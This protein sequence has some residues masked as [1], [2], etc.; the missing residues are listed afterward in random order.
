MK[1]RHFLQIIG[2][3]SVA[4]GVFPYISCANRAEYPNAIESIRTK[5][6]LYIE[7]IRLTNGTYGRFRYSTD[8]TTPTLYSSTYAAMT[9]HLYNDLDSLSGQQRQ[10]WIDYLQSHQGDD[11]LF[12]DPIVDSGQAVEHLSWH[13]TTA[14]HCLGVNARK[15]LQ[16]VNKYK[17]KKVLQNWLD[18]RRWGY[19]VDYASNIIQN[20]CVALQYARD[21]H[22]DQDAAEPVDQILEYLAN[23]VDPKTGLWGGSE[24]DLNK[25]IELSH[26]IQAA[27]HFW[28]LWIYDGKM[29]PYPELAVDQLLKTQNKNGGYGCGVHNYKNPY[30]SSACE[31]ID[32][33]DAL[34][35]LMLVSD[36]RRDDIIKS[37][38]QALP[39][40][41]TNQTDSGSWVFLPGLEYQ[42]GHPEMYAGNG[43]GGMFPTWFRTL[44][45]AYLGKGL[46][47]SSV[48]RYNWQFVKSPGSH[49]WCDVLTKREP[50]L[51][52]I[53]K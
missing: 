6:L 5:T 8:V 41:L 9:R 36:Y 4:T 32:S 19:K 17:N 2:A 46:P 51:V 52:S 20:L 10:E 40:V 31:D 33:I 7:S 39:W 37:L 15:P 50:V 26:A 1:R 43:V 22:N 35:R 29:I 28:L 45:L 3:G 18:K 34:V 21:F 42:Y 47:D 11:G 53:K 38:E 44:S 48:G 27:Y 49:F 12:R 16:W 30:L 23:R 14:L 13:V 24:Y 25:E